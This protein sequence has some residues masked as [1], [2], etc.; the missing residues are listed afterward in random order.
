MVEAMIARL[1]A[2]PAKEGKAPQRPRWSRGTSA[3]VARALQGVMPSVRTNPV[4]LLRM[5]GMSWKTARRN[6]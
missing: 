3:K 5:N 4:I 2:S 6:G 1:K